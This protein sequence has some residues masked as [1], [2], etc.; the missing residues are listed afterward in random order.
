M[1]KRRKKKKAAAEAPRIDPSAETRQKWIRGGLVVLA[2]AYLLTLWLDTVSGSRIA[3]WL[4]RTWVFFAQIAALFPDAKPMT[5]EYRAEMWSCTEHRWEELDVRPY[6]ALE[7][8]NKESRFYRTLQFYRRNRTVMNALDDY[9]VG[10]WNADG[11]HGTIG[12]VRFLSLRI[13][14]PKPGSHIEAYRYVPLASFPKEQ[15]HDWYWTKKSRRADRCG[16]KLPPKDDEPD[17]DAHKDTGG[18]EPEP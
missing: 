10:R 13:P 9:L 18:K 12:G 15:R 7:A 6:F 8:D 4:P 16:Y 1:T 2:G 17:D 3:R 5:I 11:S 14:I